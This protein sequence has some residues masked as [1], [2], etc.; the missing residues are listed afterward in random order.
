MDNAG[1]DRKPGIVPVLLWLAWGVLLAVWTYGL[2]SPTAPEV[3]QAALPTGLAFYVGKGLHLSAYAFLAC[4]ASFLPATGR[5]RAL[6]WLGLV[7]HGALTEFL[8]QFIEGRSGSLADVG[9]DTIGVGVGVL[10]G[11]AVRWFRGRAARSG[12]AG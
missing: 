3:A 10:V 9:L 6:T 5:V 4:V 7:G 11:L 12:R 2:L 8:Q 1:D